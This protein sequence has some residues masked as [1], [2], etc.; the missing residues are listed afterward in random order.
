MDPISAPS[1]P[2]SS[3]I[4]APE[5]EDFQLHELPHFP[6]FL[7]DE[8]KEELNKWG[9]HAQLLSQGHLVPKTQKEFA[10][11]RFCNSND[12]PTTRFQRLWLKYCQAA[13]AERMYELFKE[14]TE[15]DTI[16]AEDFERLAADVK[17]L[18]IVHTAAWGQVEKTKAELQTA[19]E[20]HLSTDRAQRALI[21]QYEEKLGIAQS[22]GEN[23]PTEIDG[24]VDQWREQK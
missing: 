22:A 13:Q 8:E 5:D 14:L 10:F 17:R 19:K 1:D 16:Q 3:N 6:H 15:R 23:K 7:S 4:G 9:Q 12:P 2:N 18:N 24:W 20:M 11:A 21:R